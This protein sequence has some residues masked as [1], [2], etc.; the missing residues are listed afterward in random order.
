VAGSQDGHV[1]AVVALGGADVA[2]AAMPVV[3]VVPADEGGCPG[4]GGG[5]AVKAA[6][7]EL[8]AV[9]GGAEEG[10]GVGVVVADP[11]PRVRRLDP[12]K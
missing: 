1:A 5:E 7:G 8:G 10:L 11:R 4:A 6:G 2:D 3:D 12:L 9:L